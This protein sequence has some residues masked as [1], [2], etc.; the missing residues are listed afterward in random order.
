MSLNI[1]IWKLNVAVFVA[2]LLLCGTEAYLLFNFSIFSWKNAIE[3][4]ALANGLLYL[5]YFISVQSNLSIFEKNP[6]LFIAIKQSAFAF[7]Y[8][9]TFLWII[10][11]FFH[12]HW[13][14]TVDTLLFHFSIFIA[15]MVLI[16]LGLL[17]LFV[18]TINNQEQRLLMEQDAQSLKNEAELFKLRQQLH[19]HFLFNSLN[20]INALIGSN[21]KLAREMLLKLS[22]FLRLSVK[23]EE[24]KL[25]SIREEVDSLELYLDIEKV[26]FGDRLNILKDIPENLKE[27]IIPPFLLQPLLENAIKFGLYDTLDEVIITLTLKETEYFYDFEISNPYDKHSVAPK[28]TGFGLQAISRRLFL[29]YARNDLLKVEKSPGIKKEDADIYIINLLI[30]KNKTLLK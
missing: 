8:G 14:I 21:P 25:V 18:K 12:N 26:R 1:N 22:S 24:M 11:F 4:C 10:N 20:S 5:F 2:L 15:I 9:Y 7:I 27:K 16:A 3:L 23:R 19:P 28:G 6:I 29:L 13:G 17:N 30:P